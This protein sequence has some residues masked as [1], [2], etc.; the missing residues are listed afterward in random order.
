MARRSA[1]QHG[2][3]VRRSSRRKYD[4]KRQKR[5]YNT[6]YAGHHDDILERSR[7]RFR[8]LSPE[9]KER[10]IA[11]MREA[12]KRRMEDP[13]YREKLRQQNQEYRSRLEVKERRREYKRSPETRR[14]NSENR[15]LREARKVGIATV[16]TSFRTGSGQKIPSKRLIAATRLGTADMTSSSVFLKNPEKAVKKDYRNFGVF[17]LYHRARLKARTNLSALPIGE[18]AREREVNRANVPS[19]VLPAPKRRYRTPDNIEG[20]N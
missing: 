19:E 18:V 20:K 11:Q 8:S 16:P 14:K 3:R 9:Q 1:R 17:G 7:Q 6:Y 13:Q 2:R 4:V 12:R 15:I 10:R 5:W